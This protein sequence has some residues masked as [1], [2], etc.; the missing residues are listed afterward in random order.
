MEYIRGSPKGNETTIS[1][2]TWAVDQACR[3]TVDMN[4]N[5]SHHN[6]LRG[7]L[8]T[9]CRLKQYPMATLS[10]R[11]ELRDRDETCRLNT[12]RWVLHWQTL[13]AEGNGWLWLKSAIGTIKVI[14]DQGSRVQQSKGPL[15]QQYC[16]CADSWWGRSKQSRI[17]DRRITMQRD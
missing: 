14:G 16:Q 4:G 3:S 11:K 9:G 15:K 7:G 12:V 5:I 17:V 2:T 6:S 13:D 8:N 1:D 10:H